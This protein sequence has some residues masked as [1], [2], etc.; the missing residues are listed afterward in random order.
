MTR[1]ISQE[2]L[3][4]SVKIGHRLG[5]LLA[6]PSNPK[7]RGAI[8]GMDYSGKHTP[9]GFALWVL[10]PGLCLIYFLLDSGIATPLW[11]GEYKPGR[12]LV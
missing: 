2:S 9:E 10:P 1:N 12:R 11:G 8:L 6:N 7:I 5:I 3:E 4:K